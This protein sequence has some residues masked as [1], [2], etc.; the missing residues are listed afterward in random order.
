MST[1]PQTLPPASQ[2]QPTSRYSGIP[3][4]TFTGADGRPVLYLT[5][6]F[7]ASPSS[8][9]LLQF[10]T[11]VEGDRLDNIS[12]EYLGDPLAFWR[13]CDAN[14]AMRPDDLTALPGSRIRIT[15]PQ[16]IP[17]ASHA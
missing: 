8:F 12:N 13:I 4:A 9:A 1:T 15:L 16:G 7:L 5:R 3:T 2:F 10:H 14:N 11:V 6:R 17:V